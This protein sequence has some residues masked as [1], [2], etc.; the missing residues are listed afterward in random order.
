MDVKNEEKPGAEPVEK[1]GAKPV[2][3]LKKLNYNIEAFINC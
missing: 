1:P 2:K 3:K